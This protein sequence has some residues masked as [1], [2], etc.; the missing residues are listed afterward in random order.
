MSKTSKTASVV[1]SPRDFRVK[2]QQILKTDYA[3]FYDRFVDE[4]SEEGVRI[5][6]TLAPIRSGT[7]RNS[8]KVKI[9]QKKGGGAD[10][11][12]NVTIGP[13][14]FYGRYVDQGTGP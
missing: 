10:R 1:I 8:I 9:K 11:R 14:V 3:K 2:M 5:M 6:K 4:I 7:L 13:T 12:A